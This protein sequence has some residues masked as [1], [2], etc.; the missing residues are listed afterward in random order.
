MQH[1]SLSSHSRSTFKSANLLHLSY[2]AF[3]N[4]RYRIVHHRKLHLTRDCL[5]FFIITRVQ[6]KLLYKS[7]AVRYSN[8]VSNCNHVFLKWKIWVWNP[9]LHGHTSKPLFN[10]ICLE[11]MNNLIKA[12]SP[13][14][15]LLMSCSILDIFILSCGYVL[16]ILDV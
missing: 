9:Q 16:I 11:G 4:A 15:L 10:W 1:Y 13:Y 7:K 12:C 6:I 8:C 3:L 2:H 5:M 14:R